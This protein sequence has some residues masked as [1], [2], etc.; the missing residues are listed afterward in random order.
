M[1]SAREHE[2]YAVLKDRSL[3]TKTGSTK[4]I[5]HVVLTIDSPNFFYDVGDSLAVFAENER[6]EVDELLSL[7]QICPERKV[8]DHKTKK[9]RDIHSLLQTTVDL[10]K[11]PLKLVRLV[12]TLLEPP[13][14]KKLHSFVEE[15]LSRG[16]LPVSVRSFLNT[17]GSS[18]LTFDAVYNTLAPLLPRYYS[19]ASSPKQ[20]SQQLDLTVALVSHTILDDTR[21]GLCSHFLTKRAPINDPSI[22]V[23]VH[24][25]HHFRLPKEPTAPLIMI[26]PGTGVAPFRAFLQELLY[27]RTSL[28]PCWLFFGDRQQ[29]CDFLYEDFFCNLHRSG[30]LHLDLAFSRDY[31]E[32]VYVQHKMWEKRKQLASWIDSHGAY[33]YI[34]GDAKN[35]ARSVEKTLI[36]ILVDQGISSSSEDALAYLRRMHHEKRYCRDVY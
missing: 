24:P 13:Q 2:H 30:K 31:D 10:A 5:W 12:E 27:T 20:S 14:K 23:F 18:S 6:N 15:H 22:R 21:Y 25:A 17:F 16:S 33:I 26:G 7:F 36:D 3:L 19:I 34:C 9:E 11:V 1:T 35:M 29:Q 4:E 28:P 32:K 8:L